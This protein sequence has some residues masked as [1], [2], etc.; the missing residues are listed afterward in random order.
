M[1]RNTFLKNILIN[2]VFK[3]ISMVNAICVKDDHLILF[4]SDI[5]FRDNIKYLYDHLIRQN[6]NEQYRIVCAV[7]DVKKFRE[8]NCNIKNVRI[9]SP[10][11]GIKYY[12]KSGHV[13]YS[14]GKLPI[15]P[16]KKQTVIQLWHGTSF[17]GFAENQRKTNSGKKLFYTYVYAS[18]EFFVS[19]V[20]R[21]FAVPEKKVFI[22]GHPR[23]DMLYR[24]EPK[25]DLGDF[26]KIILWLPTFRKSTQLGMKDG[27]VDNIIPLVKENELM[28]L[29]QFL[30]NIDVRLIVKLHPAQDILGVKIKK[31]T[32][33]QL[34]THAQF[35]K[36]EYDLYA[37]IRHADA[38]ITDYSSVFY[39]YLLLNRPIG[40]TE[41]DIKEYHD[42]RGFAVEDLETFRPGQ[43]I[44]TFQELKEFILNVT[45]GI[46]EFESQRMKIN[47]LANQYQDGE[48]CERTLRASNIVPM[49]NEETILS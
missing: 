35:Q 23:T 18:S 6:Y 14:F 25:Y 12:L 31:I 29:D 13:F 4:Y 38:L 28:E 8:T 21:K 40:F 7:K 46:D 34:M 39:D 27:N 48:N 16:S 2:T 15:I 22:C 42:S 41:D 10:M 3:G 33:L 5:G 26:R 30:K 20:A 47:R 44:R 24:A 32:N 36:S 17:K 19:I 43:K 9:V 45:E 37:L 49:K 1:I 11:Q